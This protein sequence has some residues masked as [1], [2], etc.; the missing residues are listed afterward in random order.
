MPKAAMRERPDVLKAECGAQQVLEL[1][2]NKWTALADWR[3]LAKDADSDAA[4]SRTQWSGH[5]QD[6]SR[7]SA[8]SGILAHLSW[9]NSLRAAQSPLPVVRA[10]T[11]PTPGP[12]APKRPRD[13]IPGFLTEGS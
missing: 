7:G 12:P 2:A 5:A 9:A 4:Q 13:G 1:I 3:H 11:H 8:S 10:A 6:L